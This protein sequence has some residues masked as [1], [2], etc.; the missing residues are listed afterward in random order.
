MCNVKTCTKCDEAKPFTEEYFPKCKRSSGGLRKICKTCR[1]SQTKE[2]YNNAYNTKKYKEKRLRLNKEYKK[3]M[4]EDLTD[5]FIK[6]RLCLN[7]HKKG[8]SLRHEDVDD[9]ELIQLKRKQ[10]WLLR[11]TKQLQKQKM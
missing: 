3:R 5:T 1:N 8:I 11:K 4:S 10:L 9:V 7:S 2:W 6:Y